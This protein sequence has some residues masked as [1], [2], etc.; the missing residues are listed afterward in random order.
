MVGTSS[1]DNLETMIKSTVLS[2]TI[3][4]DGG[5]H[6]EVL[7]HWLISTGYYFKEMLVTVTVCTVGLPTRAADS[8][9]HL[10]MVC[11]LSE[12]QVFPSASLSP[13]DFMV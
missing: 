9:S 2:L 13:G 6:S 11:G 4:R 5:R 8:G 10:H 12:F 1:L 7:P 3:K